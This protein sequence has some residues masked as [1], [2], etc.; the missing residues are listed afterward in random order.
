MLILCLC[1]GL[2][3]IINI[4][5]KG[6]REKKTIFFVSMNHVIITV[7]IFEYIY[8]AHDDDIYKI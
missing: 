6:C 8:S 4:F 7:L 2:I 3:D 1:F 5:I